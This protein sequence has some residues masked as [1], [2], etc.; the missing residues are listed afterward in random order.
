LF[1]LHSTSPR[2][3]DVERDC[4]VNSNLSKIK[5]KPDQGMRSAV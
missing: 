4:L 3:V 1:Q 5:P 2:P